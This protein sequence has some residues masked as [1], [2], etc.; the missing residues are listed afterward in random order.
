LARERSRALGVGGVGSDDVTFAEAAREWLRYCEQDRACKPSTMQAYR[1]S[2]YGRL[3]PVFGDMLIGDIAPIHIERWRASLP[4]GPR[5]KNK[6]LVEMHGIFKRARK[7]YG[8]ERN[9]AAEVE[10][11]RVPSKCDID[12]FTPEEV[13]A[14]VRAAA[15]EQDAVIYLT[16][17]FTGCDGES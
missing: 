6:L 2:V 3:I 9:P 12:V 16:A 13:M 17:A 8:L 1:S 14:L 10:H 15:D 7:M 4:V 11:L 5:M